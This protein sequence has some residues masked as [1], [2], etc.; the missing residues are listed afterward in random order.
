V[1]G[2]LETQT[3]L[4]IHNDYRPGVRR[5]RLDAPTVGLLVATGDHPRAL[6][7][8]L[9]VDVTVEHQLVEG[10]NR[11]VRI[12]PTDMVRWPRCV[13]LKSPVAAPP[14]PVG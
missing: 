5:R 12:K 1:T 6:A 10:L 7:P 8:L 11:P 4:N 13:A 2:G 9:L 14:R 3:P